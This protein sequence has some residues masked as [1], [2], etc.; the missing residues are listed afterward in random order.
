MSLN[1]SSYH[2]ISLSF[3]VIKLRLKGQVLIKIMSHSQEGSY[4]RSPYK[5]YSK[6]EGFIDEQVNK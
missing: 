6:S 5:G 2:N 4:N 1:L 3:H